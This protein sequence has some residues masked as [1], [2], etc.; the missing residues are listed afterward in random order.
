MRASVSA[1]APSVLCCVLQ[2]CVCFWPSILG[3]QS[4]LLCK[5]SPKTNQPFVFSCLLLAF[6][7]SA[8]SVLFHQPRCSLVRPTTRVSLHTLSCYC[9]FVAW[10][11]EGLF[12]LMPCWVLKRS[13]LLCQPSFPDSWYC[14][15][16]RHGQSPTSGS[17]VQS[18]RVSLL[19]P[20]T[21]GPC[22]QSLLLLKGW[23]L[24]EQFV[25]VLFLLF[26]QV[27]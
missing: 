7:F 26:L 5:S 12:P 10:L 6:I 15:R 4:P 1:T 8:A 21:Q 20:K 27:K 2:A 18:E 17:G 22:Q 23:S 16:C 25:D 13:C 3:L 9:L 11:Q 24:P 14:P 19:L